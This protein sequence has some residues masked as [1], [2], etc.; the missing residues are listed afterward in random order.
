M[1]KLGDLETLKRYSDEGWIKLKYLDE[2][3]FSLGSSVSYSYS[4]KGEQKQINQKKKEE[5]D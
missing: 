2:A 3:G 4:K 5:K 1:T